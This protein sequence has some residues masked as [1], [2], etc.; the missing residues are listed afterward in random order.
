LA[1]L[2]GVSRRVSKP[3]RTSPKGARPGRRGH[4]G[5]NPFFLGDPAEMGAADEEPRRPVADSLPARGIDWR[6]PG[7]ARSSV[8]Q[9]RAEPVAGRDHAANGGVAGGLRRLAEARSLGTA[10][11]VRVG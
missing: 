8:G 2:G 4:R 7:G 6:F 3:A 5:E 9:G 10:I 11:R 1:G